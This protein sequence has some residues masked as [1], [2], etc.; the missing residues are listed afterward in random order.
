MPV[1]MLGPGAGGLEDRGAA[2]RAIPARPT[3]AGLVLIGAALA[4]F[5]FGLET[6]GRGVVPPRLPEVGLA[7]G[8]GA[9]LGG[10]AALPAASSG[11]RSTSRLLR[12]AE[13]PPATLAGTLFR[14]GAGAVALPGADAAAGRLRQER[15][16]GRAGLLRHRARRAGDEAAGPADPAALGLPP[17]C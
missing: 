9:R 6:M 17:A 1:G 5:M 7:L 13:L 11:R 10:G 2:R 16:R 3:C 8:A 4:L 12:D 15:L 14:I